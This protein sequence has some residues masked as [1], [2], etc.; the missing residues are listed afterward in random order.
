MTMTPTV[1]T[2]PMR[3]VTAPNALNTASRLM[4]EDCVEWLIHVHMDVYG[5]YQSEDS[6]EAKTVQEPAECIGPGEES[7][8]IRPGAATLH[9]RSDAVGS[10]VVLY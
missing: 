2:T 8:T 7:T 5:K 10:P 1:R 3:I 9:G 6:Q 4:R